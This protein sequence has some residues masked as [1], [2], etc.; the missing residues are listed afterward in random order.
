[1]EIEKTPIEQ[2][3]N[4][5]A[6]AAP[7][8]PAPEQT[9]EQIQPKEATVKEE[10]PQPDKEP[11]ECAPAEPAKDM[12]EEPKE[13]AAEEPKKRGKCRKVKFRVRA[14]SG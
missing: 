7:A 9:T 13:E 1:M 8:A 14:T 4:P 6:E 5:A 3:Q 11:A 10:T 2:V 12:T